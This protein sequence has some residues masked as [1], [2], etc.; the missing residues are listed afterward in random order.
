MDADHLYSKLSVAGAAATGHRRSLNIDVLRAVAALTVLVAHSYFL[1][2][3]SAG[4]HPGRNV[5]LV[6][7]C[8]SSGVWL[9]FAISGYLIAGPFLRALLDGSPQPSAGR[10]AVRRAARILPAYWVALAAVLVFFG[11]TRLH[12]WWQLPLHAFLGQ[13]L[14]PGEPNHL[15]FVAWT[16][17]IEAM[18]YVFVPL[19]AWAVYRL[20]RR[21]AVD[22]GRLATYAIGLWIF[23]F[24]WR[25]GVSFIDTP[26][27][28]IEGHLPA[29]QADLRWV[30]PAFL[31][32]FAPGLLIFLA[33]TPQAATRG[34][35]WAL[36]RRLRSHP[37]AL[38]VTAAVLLVA[39]TK[40]QQNGGRWSDIGGT[41]TS[42]P[43]ALA[44][45][46]V[47]AIQRMPRPIALVFG[48]LGLIS[49]G[50]YLWHAV[51][52]DV[53]LAH[54]PNIVPGTGVAAW[55]PAM[56]LLAA[57]TI[58]AA[59]ASWTLIERPLLRATTN[60]DRQ[61]MS[62]RRSTAHLATEPISTTS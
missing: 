53:L 47:L 48:P 42:I 19:A 50:I 7:A 36:Y 4:V 58:P 20:H 46:G 27:R 51:V 8:F 45:M 33:E 40:L 41:L 62:L 57:L 11:G 17:S 30:L 61:R 49:Y 43:T 25:T 9:F 28:L 1:G 16:L 18:F 31:Y 10:Y 21:G 5:G 29:L 39:I 26:Q 3:G 37:V 6:I 13:D 23:S 24:A 60:W 35:G 54:V 38:L 44:L 55:L 2:A 34:G 22:V 56:V 59:L 15:L 52:R 14:V 32:A 12:H